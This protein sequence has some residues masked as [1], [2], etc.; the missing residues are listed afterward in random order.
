[1]AP[2]TML[3]SR[4]GIALLL[5][6][7]EIQGCISWCHFWYQVLPNLEFCGPRASGKPK[8]AHDCILGYGSVRKDP[9]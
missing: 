8:E 5:Y 7:K 4:K 6:I 3:D 1:M 2:T 9:V